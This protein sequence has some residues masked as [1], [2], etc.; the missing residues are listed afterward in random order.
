MKLT[1]AETRFLEEVKAMTFA[2]HVLYPRF[3][4]AR[5]RRDQIRRWRLWGKRP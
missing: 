2:A 5:I 3:K 4:R 1:Q